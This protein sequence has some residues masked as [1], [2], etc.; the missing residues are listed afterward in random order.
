MG[1]VF[2]RFGLL[3]HWTVLD[4]AA[5]GLKIQGPARQERRQRAAEWLEAVGLAG[6]EE[7]FPSQLSG[8]QQQRV[9]FAR[10]LATNA[11]ILLMDEPFSALDP[12]I[13]AEMQ[14]LLATLQARLRKTIVF[15]TH[16][17]AEALRL[18]DRI[19][20]LKDGR[21]AQVGSPTEVL[22]NPAD[23]YVR[24]FV[25]NAKRACIL[26]VAAVPCPMGSGG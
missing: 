16:D 18:G 11:D 25:A 26:P 20:I 6:Y 17:L 14:D 1:M 15:V 21:I 8:G 24:A 9:G 7:V 4:N 23:A 22:L 10:A 12:L 5:Y 3:P 2:Q 13:R 19:A